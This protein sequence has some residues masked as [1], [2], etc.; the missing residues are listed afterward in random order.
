MGEFDYDDQAQRALDA[1][2]PLYMPLHPSDFEVEKDGVVLHVMI[3]EWRP[4][5]AHV[6]ERGPGGEGPDKGSFAPY[7]R[8]EPAAAQAKMIA[9][10]WTLKTTKQ[11][12]VTDR[13]PGYGHTTVSGVCSPDVT[14][15]DVQKRF[16]HSYFG[17]RQA[18]V[19]DGRFG[20]VIHTD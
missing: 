8:M 17:G 12:I 6:I 11:M 19:R 1:G 2:A 5:I 14:V 9:D 16:Y 13:S 18:W 20:C 4:D 10:G 15:E 7:D 3:S